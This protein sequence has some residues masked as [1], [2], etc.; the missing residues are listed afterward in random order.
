MKRQRN[1][2]RRLAIFLSILFLI[3]AAYGGYSVATYGNR[4]FSSV[5][6]PR[7]R[8][9]KENVIAGNIYDRNDVLLASTDETGKRVYQSDRLSREAVVH[10]LGDAGGNVANGVETFQT[11]YLYGFRTTF[12]ELIREFF[13][14][15]PR[16]GD[17]VC[18]TIDSR[19]CTHIVSS[20]QQRKATRDHNGAAVVINY[21][22]GEILAEISLPG[23]DPHNVTGSVLDSGDQP[24]WNRATQSVYPPGSTF[25]IITAASALANL[26]GIE[27][28][29]MECTGSLEAEG[30]AIHDFGNAAHG[31]M[32]LQRAF[33][34]SCNNI[35]AQVAIRLSDARL[36][37]TAEAFGFNDNFLFRDLVVENSQYPVKSGRGE[38]E[39]GATG[40]GQSSLAATPMHMCLVAAAVAAGGTMQE[41]VLLRQVISAAGAERM[42]WQPRV[43]RQVM[44]EDVAEKLQAYMRHAVTNGTGS[45]AEM[46]DVPVCGKTGTAESTLR[47]RPVNYGWFVG[48]IADSYLPFAV[49][50]LVEDISD[51]QGGGSTAA[52]IA[53]DIF[54]YLR[55]YPDRVRY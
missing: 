13:S 53:R 24:F 32:N 21:L 49:S 52:L 51:G 11:A 36:R 50:V 9:Q 27:E 43:Y 47:G 45:R 35:Y 2:I 15:D 29:T 4:W 5:R 55:T 22:T 6:N 8:S 26:P 18:L 3:L 33:D 10:V 7:L 25:K 30:H 23:F 12:G 44:T 31:E 19:L 37:R 28:E 54:E 48:Y 1:M 38:Y 41:P 14:G 20:F 40:F 42:Y 17:D 16:H 34:V 46:P 39:V